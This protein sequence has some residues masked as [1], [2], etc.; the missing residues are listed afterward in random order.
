MAGAASP[1]PRR[2]AARCGLKGSAEVQ[3]EAAVESLVSLLDE[4]AL[5]MALCTAGAALEFPDDRPE[6][7]S[8]SYPPVGTL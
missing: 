7:V 4:L 1:T 8:P 6:P 3:E 2:H 5:L